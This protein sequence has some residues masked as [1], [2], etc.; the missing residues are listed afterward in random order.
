MNS[1][2]STSPATL[3]PEP[4]HVTA[5]RELD[6]LFASLSITSEVTGAHAAIEEG[7]G[8][9]GKGWAH[10][11]VT[12]TFT[13]SGTPNGHGR[14]T[15]KPV[16]AS[17]DYRMGTGLV[18]WKAIAKRKASF[19]SPTEARDNEAMASYGSRLTVEAQ[20]AACSRHLSAFVAKV[21][22]AEVLASVCRDGEDASGQSFADFAA[23]Y[24]YDEDSRK[25][26]SVYR[27]CQEG[28]DKARKLLAHSP[29]A[30]SKLTELAAQL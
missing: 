30:F 3:A 18:D 2:P 23:N 27:A 22:P 9:E 14:N 28:G 8:H 15:G 5:R 1:T 25:A 13:Y 10:V 29:G 19:Q 16:S 6:A 4:S 17:F 24:G 12:V 26:E 21:S 11:A 7:G 20:C